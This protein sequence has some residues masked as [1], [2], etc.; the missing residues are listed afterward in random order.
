MKAPTDETNIGCDPAAANFVLDANN[1]QFNNVYYVPVEVAD[2]IGGDDYKIFVD[3]ANSGEAPAAAATLE[4]YK[5]WSEAGRADETLLVHGEAMKYD[6][7]TESTP[8]FDPVAI[9]LALDLLSDNCDKENMRMT[10]FE[11]EV[12]FLEP[13]DG[14]KVLLTMLTNIVLKLTP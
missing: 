3:A 5:I 10:L 14:T 13:S 6:P 2:R 8:Q 11:M 7:E 9:M 1:I 12:R 4:W